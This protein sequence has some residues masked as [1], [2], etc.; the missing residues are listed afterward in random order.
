MVKYPERLIPDKDCEIIDDIDENEIIGRANRNIA[1]NTFTP[2]GDFNKS[3]VK[4]KEVPRLSCN[5]LSLSEVDDLLIEPLNDS[6]KYSYSEWNKG[7]QTPNASDI[8]FRYNE[9]WETYFFRKSDIE[10][11]TTY[12]FQEKEYSIK[13]DMKHVPV[14]INYSHSEFEITDERRLEIKNAKVRVKEFS[15]TNPKPG[16]ETLMHLLRRKLKRHVRKEYT[17]FD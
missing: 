14:L 15:T 2:N 1:F 17:D 3:S 16:Q 5:L 6:V 8:D 4:V 10:F 13:L 12:S 9:K 11:D 7:K